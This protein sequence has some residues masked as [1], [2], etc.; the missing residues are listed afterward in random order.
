MSLK[1]KCIFKGQCASGHMC[2]M[3]SWQN[4]CLNI[5]RAGR[6]AI[7]DCYLLIIVKSPCKTTQ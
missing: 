3:F 1:K 4:H 5:T 6:G 2:S 7:A